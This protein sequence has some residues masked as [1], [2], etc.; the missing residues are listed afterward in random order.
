VDTTRLREQADRLRELHHGER[1]LVLPNAWDAVS[2]RLVAAE[3]FPVVATTSSGVA[4]ALGYDDHEGAPPDEVFAAVGRITRAVDVP[5]TA[6]L[7]AGYGLA[8]A[9]LAERILDAGVAGCNL[10]DTDHRSGGLAAVKDAV[11]SAGADVV[12]NARVDV[13]LHGEG[14]EEHRLAESLRRSRDYLAAGADCVYP[15]L[16]IDE[17]TIR[18][19]VHRVDGPVNV[20]SKPGAPG[21]DELAAM[22]V[23]RISFGGGLHML[24]QRTLRQALHRIGDGSDPYSA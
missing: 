24:L 13:Y 18:A 23:A 6:D 12:I 22:G 17:P 15:I 7:E 16:V 19:L 8:P 14:S 5:V 10:E 20:L 11:R 2:A 21:L 9:E 4:A 3:G 1:P